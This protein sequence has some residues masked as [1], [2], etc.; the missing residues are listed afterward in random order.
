MSNPASEPGPLVELQKPVEV[1][2]QVKLVEIIWVLNDEA[3]RLENAQN[4]FVL[5]G[6]IKEPN[7]AM[8]DRAHVMRSGANVMAELEH[9]WAEVRELLVA[10]RKKKRG[11]T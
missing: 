7:A 8:M 10:R 3:E 1:K 11:R 2:R 9:I 4:A 6:L 5:A